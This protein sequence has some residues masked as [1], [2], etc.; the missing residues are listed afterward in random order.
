VSGSSSGT[1]GKAEAMSRLVTAYGEKAETVLW[2][3]SELAPPARPVSGPWAAWV[4]AAVELVDGA[5][6]LV[7]TRVEL[8]ETEYARS[9]TFSPVVVLLDET[10]PWSRISQ[11]RET[12]EKMQVHLIMVS[13][14]GTVTAGPSRFAPGRDES[15]G[16]AR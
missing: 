16:E 11:V 13:R 15:D 14:D 8:C 2:V 9:E 7:A 1:G 10:A 5:L 4:A 6:R 12:A 3:A